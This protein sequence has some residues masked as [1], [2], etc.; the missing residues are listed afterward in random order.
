MLKWEQLYLEQKSIKLLIVL[1]CCFCCFC[2][3]IFFFTFWLPH[4]CS[5]YVFVFVCMYLYYQLDSSIDLRAW[6]CFN[7]LHFK[8]KQRRHVY[9]ISLYVILKSADIVFCLLNVFYAVNLHGIC[10]LFIIINK[11]FHNNDKVWVFLS[12]C[13]R[14]VKT[15]LLYMDAVWT[16]EQRWWSV[17]FG[18]AAM[19]SW[20]VSGELITWYRP[21]GVGGALTQASLLLIWAP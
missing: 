7:T 12:D 2:F 1:F 9:F 18:L 5:L 21:C 16:D 13:S 17:R 3:M 6:H 11:S 4:V 14:R 8:V 20:L 15:L 10:M 19:K